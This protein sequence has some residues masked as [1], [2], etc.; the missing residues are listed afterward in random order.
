MWQYSLT[1]QVPGIS[2]ETDLDY[3]FV[4]VAEEVE[5]VD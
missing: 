5:E 1:G 2:V 3:I 4:P